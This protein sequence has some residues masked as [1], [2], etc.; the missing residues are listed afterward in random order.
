MVKCLRNIKEY[1]LAV[2]FFSNDE[3]I[4]SVILRIWWIVE[5]SNSLIKEVLKWKPLGKRLLGRPKQR[6]ID[7]VKKT[8]EEFGIQDMDAVAQDRDRWKQICVAVRKTIWAAK[9]MSSSHFV[10]FFTLALVETY[11]DIIL[12]NHMD[13]TDIIKFFNDSERIDECIDFTMICVSFI[14][15]SVTSVWGSKTACF[16]FFQQYLVRWESESSWLYTMTGEATGYSTMSVRRIVYEG[17]KNMDLTGNST[18]ATFI[19][20]DKKRNNVTKI[21]ALVDDFDRCAL[22]R[23]I[24]NM[25]TVEKIVPTVKL[26]IEKQKNFMNLGSTRTLNRII[27]EMGFKFRKTETN[28]KLLIEKHNIRKRLIIVHAGGEEGFVPNA[29]LTWEAQSSSGDYHDNMNKDNYYKC[30]TEKL[31]PNL[32][33]NSVVVLDNAT[34]HCHQSN[35]APNSN[36]LKKDMI[37]WLTEN[38]ISFNSTM[39][40]PQLY[41]IIRKHK[42]VFIKYSL[43]GILSKEGHDIIRLPPYHPDLNPIEMIW[44][45]VKQYIA[46][47]NHNG[48]IKKIAELC[49]QKMESMGKSEWGAVCANVKKLETEMWKNESYMDIEMDKLIVT[50]GEDTTDDSDTSTEDED[51]DLGVAP[52]QP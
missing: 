48:S 12:A 7:K 51:D 47:Q 38:N 50:Y 31:L 24:T 35:R 11:R 14:L 37:N 18:L 44:S 52:L 15:V 25:Y 20:P 2:F 33:K 8:L 43:D 10:L 30:V 23:T 32:S 49:K 21:K 40:K 6:W 19:T 26:I 4:W 22:K 17:K 41:D 42:Q 36:S 5:W 1:T 13:F 46:K 16:D 45:Q 29:L 34:Y 27:S 9:E 28:R 3:D 39:F